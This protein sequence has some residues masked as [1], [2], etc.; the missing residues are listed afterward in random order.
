MNPNNPPNVNPAYY[1][2]SGSLNQQIQ[3]QQQRQQQQQQ[4]Q[5]QQNQQG[6]NY[7]QNQQQRLVNAS[8]LSQLS[9][10]QLNYLNAAQVQQLYGNLP[11]GYNIQQTGYGNI[12][13]QGY[14]LSQIQPQ[15]QGQGNKL[16]SNY[17]LGQLQ[18]QNAPQQPQQEP[19][20]TSSLNLTGNTPQRTN[21]PTQANEKSTTA[22]QNVVSKSDLEWLN[23]AAFGLS[24]DAS[25]L[26]S[27]SSSS[28]QNISTPLSS[29]HQAIA[30]NASSAQIPNMGA[31][32]AMQSSSL[33]YQLPVSGS[34][35]SQMVPNSV[36]QPL[37]SMSN[38]SSLTPQTSLQSSQSTATNAATKPPPQSSPTINPNASIPMSSSISA[39][40][41][42]IP[43]SAYNMS[44]MPAQT[45]LTNQMANSSLMQQM[46]MRNNAQLMNMN[47]MQAMNMN[48]GNLA[49]YQNL[50]LSNLNM[51]NLGSL[52]GMPAGTNMANLQ[53][54][55]TSANGMQGMNRPPMQSMYPYQVMPGQNPM[56]AM[57]GNQQNMMLQNPQMMRG[58]ISRKSSLASSLNPQ[59][60]AANQAQ[61][62]SNQ[63]QR[64]AVANSTKQ[65]QSNAQSV[66]TTLPQPSAQI[67]TQYGSQQPSAQPQVS[68]PSH[69]QLSDSQHPQPSPKLQ[70][71]TSVQ[72]SHSPSPS[73]SII[74]NSP[75]QLGE[76]PDTDSDPWYQKLK[77][78]LANDNIQFRLPVV[79]GTYLDLKTLF[80]SV[81]KYGGFEIVTQ[82][83][84]W[85]LINEDVDP[86]RVSSSMTAS[87]NKTYQTLLLPLERHLYPSGI[88]HHMITE[89]L[90]SSNP[91]S[92][93]STPVLN[94]RNL[95][96][97]SAGMA[98][99]KGMGQM[100]PTLGMGMQG[101]QMPMGS[102]LSMMQNV[103]MQQGL[104]GP[105]SMRMNTGTPIAGM[106]TNLEQT[107]GSKGAS[108]GPGLS[109]NM[110]LEQFQ[111]YQEKIKQ[112]RQQQQQQPASAGSVG[113][114]GLPTG[115]QGASKPMQ[116]LPNQQGLPSQGQLSRQQSSAS[117]AS[118]GSFEGSAQRRSD[119]QDSGL[120]A[121]F[122]TI[123]NEDEVKEEQKEASPSLSEATRRKPEVDSVSANSAAPSKQNESAQLSPQ[124]KAEAATQ[125][126][127]QTQSQSAS[128]ATP[129]GVIEIKKYIP[130][131]RP[132][133]PSNFGGIELLSVEKYLSPINYGPENKMI[134]RWKPISK[135]P[136]DPEAIT[137]RNE[138]G[139]VNVFA[140]TM[141]IKSGLPIEV[142]NALNVL[143]VVSSDPAVKFFVMYCPDLVISLVDLGMREW[144]KVMSEWKKEY[145]F[146]HLDQSK[147]FKKKKSGLE[148][149]KPLSDTLESTL[150]EDPVPT[151]PVNQK[152]C[153]ILISI[154][155]IVRNLT[156]LYENTTYFCQNTKFIN[157]MV[158]ILHD[159][160]WIMHV[161]SHNSGH[162]HHFISL[163]PY[164]RPRSGHIPIPTSLAT[165][166]FDLLD[167]IITIVSNIASGFVVSIPNISSPVQT[168]ASIFDLIFF[169]YTLPSWTS[170][171]EPFGNHSPKDPISIIT[172]GAPELGNA[173]NA[174][175][176]FSEEA[177]RLYRY[178]ATICVGNIF[179][180]VENRG[181]LS[182]IFSGQFTR[183]RYNRFE[184]LVKL[185]KRNSN[186]DW[187]LGNSDAFLGSNNASTSHSKFSY[188]SYR[189]YQDSLNFTSLLSVID[190]IIPDSG[191]TFELLNS[192][193]DIAEL[194]MMLFCISSLLSIDGFM[195][196][197]EKGWFYGY[198]VWWKIGFCEL[199]EKMKQDVLKS[200]RSRTSA[201][202]TSDDLDV[203]NGSPH[204]GPVPPIQTN[205]K[206]PP[207]P[208]IT[209]DIT[210]RPLSYSYSP[211]TSIYSKLILL[212]S[213]VSFTADKLTLAF[214][215][216]RRAIS[217]V[218]ENLPKTVVTSNTGDEKQIVESHIKTW[219]NRI[220]STILDGEDVVFE[221]DSTMDQFV[222][223]HIHTKNQGNSVTRNGNNKSSTSPVS[224]KR[225]TVPSSPN[226]NSSLKSTSP[227]SP[228]KRLYQETELNDD[229][230]DYFIDGDIVSSFPERF[231]F[232]G[233]YSVNGT[234]N[235]S[236]KSRHFTI[237]I[238]P[239]P[240]FIPPPGIF[241][242]YEILDSTSTLSCSDRTSPASAS[243]TQSPP[244]SPV[245]HLESQ[246]NHVGSNKTVIE[247][248]LPIPTPPT[249]L[250]TR[251]LKTILEKLTM[252]GSPDVMVKEAGWKVLFALE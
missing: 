51:Q 19:I 190:E 109:F 123:N 204:V 206:K 47:S 124:I 81:V 216:A 158:S 224:P 210:P 77:A 217:I 176:G 70:S 72:P 183:S 167:Q 35:S 116:T 80:E 30:T 140:L 3:Q 154:F 246:N 192:H 112:F 221:L 122:T 43:T 17:N 235:R 223:S 180:N 27:P 162:H 229:W 149:T 13:P 20:S 100:S 147:T 119:L 50:G 7:Q 166:A 11:L 85:R 75:S 117:V 101:V 95:N 143:T 99:P 185:G 205:V 84:K 168:A 159:C 200:R 186:D 23:L 152:S 126:Q 195:E 135:L 65:S 33:S 236:I 202:E 241:G 10:Q 86:S 55:G 181:V 250:H 161:I 121:E 37:S 156:F 164:L 39:T 59:L 222:N 14:N 97:Q 228:I 173:L 213:N 16:P 74:S 2:P 196:G 150:L 25:N 240:E 106:V 18:T 199:M 60:Q 120:L 243:P 209:L 92:A 1:Y 171:L 79:G 5:S 215:L 208:I 4:Q 165:T 53:G 131:V 132:I 96:Q 56:L 111:A 155:T 94:Q 239:T 36:S 90:S 242:S 177:I 211:L 170:I 49:A 237:T 41:S 26:P 169:F 214:H 104:Q 219:A 57:Y 93:Q 66:S 157:W 233:D 89:Q 88:P 125:S 64:H 107:P 48:L 218:V 76:P 188:I 73:P 110:N 220:C 249:M 182:Q 82:T 87:L 197:V 38:T 252:G 29:S 103:Q 225:W 118:V 137:L 136:S 52:Q 34:T 32:S 114:G 28:A 71:P 105:Q 144:D 227:L 67:Y 78:V 141:C 231:G 12:R 69:A 175:L 98:F 15:S 184:S 148:N 139:A 68:A 113:A 134:Y 178:M 187:V 102:Q 63:L 91:P 248:S 207:N 174:G 172:E 58:N 46:Q 232:Q 160:L 191:I 45:N 138:L 83:R 234:H 54:Y 146:A 226:R 163:P 193:D 244:T 9:P 247:L 198:E 24:S 179:T 61:F 142:T 22:S 238:D 127:G 230:L 145:G 251:K 212:A 108:G 62:Q 42:S 44:N 130:V 133:H 40:S 245:R 194:E 21:Q 128:S 115:F 189:L 153:Q 8:G 201:T 129:P 31:S 203:T 6:Q 151:F